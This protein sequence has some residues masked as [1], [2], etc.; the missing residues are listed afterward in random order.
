M[1]S[2]WM[3]PT[4][5]NSCGTKRYTLKVCESSSTF[6]LSNSPVPS[7]IQLCG[8]GTPTLKSSS[9]AEFGFILLLPR[10]IRP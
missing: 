7:T 1:N 3:N 8:K 2:V 6:Y 10:H 5:E 9:C 4:L